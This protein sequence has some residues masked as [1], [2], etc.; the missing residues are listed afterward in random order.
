[1]VSLALQHV[2]MLAA[3]EAEVETEAAAM[4]KEQGILRT[5]ETLGAALLEALAVPY[6]TQAPKGLCASR[7]GSAAG[8]DPSGNP[9]GTGGRLRKRAVV[10]L[11]VF[12]QQRKERMAA[13]KA[14]TRVLRE[15]ALQRMVEGGCDQ[16]ASSSSLKACDWDVEKAFAC[17]YRTCR[18]SQQHLAS[19]RAQDMCLNQSKSE[20]T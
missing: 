4:V 20:C 2:R 11:G 15:T 13:V 3:E 12:L 8:A 19:E 1:M 17:Y 5:G 14:D 6:A 18:S 9:S 7:P 10:L 16:D